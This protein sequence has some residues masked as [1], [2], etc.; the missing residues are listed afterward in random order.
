MI[1]LALLSLSAGLIL[2]GTAY[3]DTPDPRVYVQ[4]LLK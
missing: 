4:T 3:S 1:L 2:I